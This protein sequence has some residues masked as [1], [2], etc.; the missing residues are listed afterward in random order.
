M[1]DVSVSEDAGVNVHA[2]FG[3]LVKTELVEM[4]TGAPQESCGGS[5]PVHLVDDVVFDG[6]AADAGVLNGVVGEDEGVALW[7]EVLAGGVVAD[8]VSFSFE[9]MV[10]AG[11]AVL[12]GM[13]APDDAS[14]PVIFIQVGEIT[15]ADPDVSERVA[16][17][18]GSSW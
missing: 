12:P 13:I 16:R 9:I 1:E 18:E 14:V 4:L 10:L 6:S 7:E 3:L 8:R 15:A 11:S 5:I 2:V 17:D